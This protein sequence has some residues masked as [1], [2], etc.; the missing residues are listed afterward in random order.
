M[1]IEIVAEEHP[2]KMY[3]TIPVNIEDGIQ[4]EQTQKMAKRLGFEGDSIADAQEQADQRLVIDSVICYETAIALRPK[5]A[6]ARLADKKSV[7]FETYIV[8][9]E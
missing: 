9:D 7:L 4:A 6:E 3:I 1:D 8:D 2:D 5:C